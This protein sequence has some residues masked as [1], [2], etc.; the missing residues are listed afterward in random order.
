[1]EWSAHPREGG[2]PSR[3]MSECDGG[4]GD[5]SRTT[6][7][8]H[9]YR[10]CA[11][12]KI[13]APIAVARPRFARSLTRPKSLDLHPDLVRH[14]SSMAEEVNPKPVPS[15]Y[16]GCLWLGG[17]AIIIFAIS[18]CD[19]KSGSYQPNAVAS[20]AVAPTDAA[21]PISPMTEQ[22]TVD[23]KIGTGA[24]AKAV[25]VDDATSAVIFSK[26]CYAALDARFTW[27]KL[28][29]CGA[30]DA[31]T[32]KAV[33][34]ERMTGG[35]S[36]TAYLSEENGAQRFISSGVSHGSSADGMDLRWD[37]TTRSVALLEKQARP[38]PKPTPV[39]SEES[40]GEDATY[41]VDEN[42]NAAPLSDE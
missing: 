3:E 6:G 13:V 26:N 1:M 32:A 22:S 16:Q 12:R 11:T 9:F 14:R 4:F 39:A 25:A 33:L 28:D 31:A 8:H 27:T 7:P 23:V 42:G 19:K 35:V 10:G 30:F 5:A 34:A 24:F 15:K 29:Q 41:T 17:V 18:Q 36:E 2:G 20:D 21:L 38:K 37:K 40:A